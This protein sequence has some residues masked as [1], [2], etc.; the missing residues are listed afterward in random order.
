MQSRNGCE[1]PENAEAIE[2]VSGGPHAGQALRPAAIEAAGVIH[3]LGNLIQIASSAIAVIARSPEM[4]AIHSGPMLSRAKASLD[5][6]GAIVRQRLG[7]IRDAEPALRD[8]IVGECLANV[9]ALI[10]GLYEPDFR[11]EIGLD[12]DL[13]WIRCDPLGLQSAILNLVINARDAMEGIG[14][15]AITVDRISHGPL[16]PG[17]EFRISDNGPGMS[18][19]TISRAF[20]PFF[21]TRSSGS[22]GVGLPMVERFVV[23]AGGEIAIQSALEVGTTVILRLPAILPSVGDE[24]ERGAGVAARYVPEERER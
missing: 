23:E 9:A 13:P 16:A 18:P 5:Q 19:A 2:I 24:R 14:R 10:D 8:A 22:G 15:V 11:L 21:T 6:A 1:G 7:L 3:D 4:P 17:V 20:S 12:D